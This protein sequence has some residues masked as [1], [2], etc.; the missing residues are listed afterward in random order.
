MVQYVETCWQVIPVVIL[1]GPH[2]GSYCMYRCINAL[3]ERESGR[4]SKFYFLL[5]LDGKLLS[6][7]VYY[8]RVPP[9]KWKP[10]TKSFVQQKRDNSISG[11]WSGFILLLF[12]QNIT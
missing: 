6:E 5:G 7:H 4:K 3:T 9:D 1:G 10:G 2:Q 11:Q 8:T 12:I